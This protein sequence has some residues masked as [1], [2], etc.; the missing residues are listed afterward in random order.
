MA[1]CAVGHSLTPSLPLPP[2]GERITNARR[3]SYVRQHLARIQRQGLA[4]GERQEI[5]RLLRLIEQDVSSL[6]AA[7]ESDIF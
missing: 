6:I 3:L 1:V 2:E 5:L 4:A 7:L